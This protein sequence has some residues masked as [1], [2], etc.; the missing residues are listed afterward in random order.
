MHDL[1]LS[2]DAKC[3]TKSIRLMKWRTDDDQHTIKALCEPLFVQDNAMNLLVAKSNDEREN[4][5][6]R[7]R[8]S[9]HGV[10]N[11]GHDDPKR[12]PIH[13]E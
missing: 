8:P 12:R 9:F 6:Q 4:E 7:C 10:R 2:E 1:G 13:E 5:Q 3:Y 11:G